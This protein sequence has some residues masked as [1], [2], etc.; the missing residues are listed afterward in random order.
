M[1]N[2]NRVVSISSITILVTADG[3]GTIL[4]QVDLVIQSNLDC[5]TFDR[6][7]DVAIA[8]LS[9]FIIRAIAANLQR[10]VEFLGNRFSLAIIT[11]EV[12]AIVQ[13]CDDVLAALAVFTILSILIDNTGDVLAIDA[14]ST[15]LADFTV[16]TI[17]ALFGRDDGRR[18][19]LFAILTIDAVLTG[20]ADRT[21]LPIIAILTSFT[22]FAVFTDGNTIASD[23]LIHE[24]LDRRVS[25]NVL[26]HC[27]GQVVVSISMVGFSI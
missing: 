16:F 11:D 7:L 27:R 9:L 21:F 19:A 5:S 23:V 4:M 6:S 14:R 22:I 20:D 25:I 26:F 3:Q 12:Q 17:L 8:L 1:L 2:E 24:D 18:D 10:I 15:L 13:C